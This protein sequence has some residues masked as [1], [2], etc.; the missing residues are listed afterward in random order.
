MAGGNNNVAANFISYVNTPANKH[1]G[2]ATSMFTL[3]KRNAYN[4]SNN[5]G[6][7]LISA[8]LNNANT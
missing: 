7:H 6:G 1:S 4:I 3:K 8:R 5:A 2:V